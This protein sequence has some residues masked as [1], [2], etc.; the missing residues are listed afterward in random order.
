MRM[1]L[2]MSKAVLRWIIPLLGL[3]VVGPLAGLCTVGLRA[4]DGSGAVT[5]ILAASPIMGLGVGLAAMLLAALVGLVGTWL[6][7]FKTGIFAAGLTLAW[8][9]W[10]TGNMDNIMRRTQS[11]DV[12]WRLSAEGL[13]FGLFAVA[14]AFVLLRVEAM[15]SARRVQAHQQVWSEQNRTLVPPDQGGTSGAKSAGSAL[16]PAPQTLTTEELTQKRKAIVIGFALVIAV[17]IPVVWAV[18]TE[19]L[20]GQVLAAAILAAV[21]GS[22]AGRSW[23]NKA[24]LIVFFAAIALLATVSPAAAT[25]WHSGEPALVRASLAGT[26]FPPARLVPLDWI[27]GA[28]IGIPLGLSLAGSISAMPAREA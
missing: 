17:A 21:L 13:I 12:L 16:A 6:I 10:G 7:S 25:L 26:L 14:I 4:A 1:I 3:F 22:A 27:A 15:R 2:T 9:A 28:F 5:P 23:A 19:A 8:A 18:A 24:P 11:A 20:K